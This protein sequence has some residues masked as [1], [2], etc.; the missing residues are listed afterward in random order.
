MISN[1]QAHLTHQQRQ[2][3]L[4]H[5]KEVQSAKAESAVGSKCHNKMLLGEVCSCI[6][7]WMMQRLIT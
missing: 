1:Y 2:G 5:T 6:Q 4:N 3:L 7:L